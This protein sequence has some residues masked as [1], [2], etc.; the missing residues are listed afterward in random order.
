MSRGDTFPLP[1]DTTPTP[2]ALPLGWRLL[3]TAA[4]LAQLLQLSIRQVRRL[5]AAGD[6]P[7]RLT[8]GAL[9]RAVRYQSE[10]VREWIA[11]GC[12]DRERWEQLQRARRVGR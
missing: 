12:P 10:I 1:P 3:L 5:D 4:D 8:G 7:G 11:A 9:G 6:L 2:T